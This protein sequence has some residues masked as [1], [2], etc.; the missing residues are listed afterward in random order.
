MQM[1]NRRKFNSC[2]LLALKL[3]YCPSI[4]YRAPLSYGKKDHTLFLEKLEVLGKVRPWK[5]LL[6]LEV[7]KKVLELRDRKTLRGAYTTWYVFSWQLIVKQR[8]MVSFPFEYSAK[9]MVVTFPFSF[10]GNE[11]KSNSLPPLASNFSF[12]FSGCF[13]NTLLGNSLQLRF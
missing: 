13:P 7:K 11:K 6:S 9:G 1:K 4:L 10:R 2:C 8:Q 3:H 5:P 12:P